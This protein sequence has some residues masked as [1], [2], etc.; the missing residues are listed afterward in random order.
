MYVYEARRDITVLGMAQNSLRINDLYTCVGRL[1]AM[2]KQKG[3]PT[4]P[5]GHH[6]LRMSRVY[7]A[8]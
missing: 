5:N 4:S 7:F 1:V 6:A 2:L 3:M 8:T